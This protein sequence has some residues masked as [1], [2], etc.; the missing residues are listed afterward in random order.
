M[1]N[2]YTIKN[3][4]CRDKY[5]CIFCGSGQWLENVPHHCFFKSEYFADD[6]DDDWNLVTVCKNCHFHIHHK[7]GGKE[8]EKIGKIIAYKK[9]AG[10]N[11]DKLE[12]ILKVKRISVF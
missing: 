7:S 10:Q 3:V 11:K 12:R 2:Q 1:V 5:T 4:L 9:Y 6:R 8:K